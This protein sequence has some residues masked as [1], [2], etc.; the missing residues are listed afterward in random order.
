MAADLPIKRAFHA[1]N[2]CCDDN[3]SP[4]GTTVVR[5]VQDCYRAQCAR[6]QQVSSVDCSGTHAGSTKSPLETAVVH[7][8]ITPSVIYSL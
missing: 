7:V 2:E 8:V 3:K 6:Q 4:L 5:I 1:D